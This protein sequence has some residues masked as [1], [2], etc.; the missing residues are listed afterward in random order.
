[1]KVYV[2]V[3][4]H[5]QQF[6]R[7]LEAVDLWV[8]K[9][10]NTNVFAQTGN[11]DYLPKHF[12]SQK[13]LSD[14]EYEKNMKNSEVIV[15]HAGA[16]TIINALNLKKSIVIIPRLKKFGEHTNDHQLELADVLEKEGLVL[17]ANEN[18]FS[19]VIQKARNFKPKIRSEKKK[20][21]KIINDFLS[22][23]E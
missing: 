8:K 12:K 21:I 17:S 20:T 9:S 1:M 16:G 18:N 13:F 19:D 4:T 15:T 5:R 3:G 14:K 22:D 10:K 7:L 23:L 11:S 6:N 2:T